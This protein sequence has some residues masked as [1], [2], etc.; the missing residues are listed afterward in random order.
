MKQELKIKKK[1]LYIYMDINSGPYRMRHH[2]NLHLLCCKNDHNGFDMKKSTSLLT[3]DYRL[4]F[5]GIC[6]VANCPVKYR[7]VTYLAT[8]VTVQS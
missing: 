7:I 5:E 2:H 1:P 6:R 8:K 3:A 4:Q